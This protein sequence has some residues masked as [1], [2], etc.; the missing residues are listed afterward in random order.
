MGPISSNEES[1]PALAGYA[2][3]FAFGLAL[4]VGGA[5]IGVAAPSVVARAQGGP[6]ADGPAASV[7]A[8]AEQVCDGAA[9]G[10]EAEPFVRTELFFGTAKPDGTAVTEEEWRA[11]VDREL[12]PRFPEGLTV[13][14]G[15]GQWQD[16][17]DEIVKERSKLVILLYP[18][19]A[20]QE[21]GAEIEEIRAAYERMFQQ[22]SV[23]RADEGSEPV[24]VSF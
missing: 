4:T 2:R 7:A 8:Q 3:A 6:G 18:R 11:F 10:V 17:D 12:T 15:D 22:E 23:L 1:A 20:E 16:A 9:A 24:C 13:L 21:S 19:S 5:G 14:S